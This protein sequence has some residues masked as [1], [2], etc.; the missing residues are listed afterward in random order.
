MS[1]EKQNRGRARWLGTLLV[2]VTVTVVTFTSQ[3]KAGAA[4]TAAPVSASARARPATGAPSLDSDSLK[5]AFRD[6]PREYSIEPL[7]SWNSAL[8]RDRLTWQ[9]DQMVEKGVYGA[10]M[11]V[12][13]GMDETNTPYFSDGF[14]DGVRASVEHGEKVGFRTWLYDED[15]W[16]SGDAGGRTRAAN[17]ERYSAMQLVHTTEQVRGPGN[18]PLRFP[19]K[20]FVVAARTKAE[21]AI[22]ETTLTDLTDLNRKTG[23]WQIPAGEW[24]ISVF[25]I[26]NGQRVSP[27]PNYINP[28]A[29]AEFIRLTHEEYA[30]RFSRYFGKTIPGVFFD[31]IRN[32]VPAWD[33]IL[34]E[35]FRAHKGYELRKNL[36]LL[37]LDGGPRTIKFRCDYF[38]ELTKLFEDSWFKQISDWCQ[39]HNLKLTGHTQERLPNIRT[40]GDYFRTWRHP[41]QPGTDNEDF[42]YTWPR[43]IGAW[44]PK[45]LS[46][47]T[48]VYGKPRAMAESL[49]G[50]GWT[51]TLD[52][53]K[54]G[55]NM[56][57]V[58]GINS[59]VF[60]LFHYAMDMRQS[61][62]DWPNSWFYQNPYWKYFKKFADHAR[63][64][65]FLTAQGEHVSNIAVLYPVED[66]WSTG[67]T[68]TREQAPVEEIVDRLVGEQLDFDLVDTDNVL[69]ANAAKDG[70]ARIGKES[71]R[72]LVLPDVATVSLAAYRK[73]AELAAAGFPV[74]PLG[75]TPRHSAEN[76]AD[77][78][79]VLQIS[80]KLFS[81]QAVVR[82]LDSLTTEL[83]KRAMSEIDVVSGDKAAIRY[84]HRRAGRRDFYFLTN[85][86]SKPASARIRFPAT[87]KIEKWDPE[88]GQISPSTASLVSG[89]AAT[90]DLR[91]D[92]WQGYFIVFDSSVPADASAVQAKREQTGQAIA[93][94]GPWSFQLAQHEL[95]YSWKADPGET[96]VE[97]PVADFRVE[98]GSQN[99]AWHRVKLTDSLNPLKGAARYLSAWDAPWITA[100]MYRT[101][102]R[103]GQLG[104]AQLT[105]GR[106]FQV[107]FEPLSG[108]LEALSDGGL[109][110]S[111][112]GKP[113]GSAAAMKPI[114]VQNLP[115][116]QGA[117]S[118]SCTVKGGTRPD[119]WREDAAGFLLVQ[120]ELH[121]RGGQVVPIRTSSEWK[122]SAL[123]AEPLPAYE[124]AWPPFGQWGDVPLRDRKQTLPAT[125]SY[126]VN[127]PP[128]AR[129]LEAPEVR[130]AWRLFV[131]GKPVEPRNG[132]L[133]VPGARRL[134]LRAELAAA[135]DGLQRSLV[136][137]CG[138]APGRLG[139]W[140]AAGLDWYS[141][142]GIYTTAFDLPAAASGKKLT[143]DLG[144]LR[145]TGEM[146]LNGKLV[147]TMI[148]APY[149][150]DVTKFAKPGRNE[151][152]VV[153]ANLLANE[154]RWNLFD[155]AVAVPM[156]RWW[157]DG[158]ILR[159]GDKLSSG[160]FG[161]VRLFI[162]M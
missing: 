161:P 57:A 158:N 107:A 16:P 122:V 17:P 30:K 36:P 110:C 146:W 7:W 142:R 54:Y 50:A 18:K 134:V 105:F 47:V 75:S 8:E 9:I 5:E 56:L 66:V 34:E 139:D 102:R 108:W 64:L 118:I 143:L 121:G 39:R 157:H 120:G 63:R 60:H 99:A 147:E 73:I 78:P 53:A 59:F 87:G 144:D 96:R 52:Q 1:V 119:D 126:A 38:E 82:D 12:R 4:G 69:A 11:H 21:G 49:G 42:R 124:F 68:R 48:H 150:A 86:E 132:R 37:F 23:D 117:N 14:W 44:K 155:S 145:Y 93:L 149:S 89:N 116:R 29:I 25:E 46:S 130:G 55:V 129:E 125:V 67:V 62:D 3:R 140:Q 88:S 156:S 80:Q 153:V 40:Q 100:Y 77:D 32:W 27:L 10:Y 94:N 26:T 61:M 72:V 112:N 136:F 13:V 90:L 15:K 138:R 131:D 31:E 106:D 45:Q 115:A 160:L 91:F 76:G 2:L 148:W 19:D 41:Q 85:S 28:N 6:P 114:S 98:R 71:Y 43:T 65:S 154:M 20:A 97:M 74:I 127:V 135:Q 141:G 111:L 104:G 95:D 137:R 51:I 92:R 113:L 162:T 109:T 81:K 103:G 79:E 83:R 33:P 84:L 22:D 35:R 101:S 152:V 24:T 70:R 133:P 159:D 128:G 123:N 58:Y 151:L